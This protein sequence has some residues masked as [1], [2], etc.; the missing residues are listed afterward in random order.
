LQHDLHVA[1]CPFGEAAFAIA[2]IELPHAQ[3]RLGITARMDALGIGQQALA[4]QGEGG[5]VMQADVFE[6]DDAQG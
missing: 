4:P 6:V 3:Q 5:G 1:Q 2:K